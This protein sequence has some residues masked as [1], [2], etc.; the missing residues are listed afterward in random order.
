L[1]GIS[2]MNKILALVFALAMTVSCT[3]PGGL[4]K[5]NAPAV[6]GHEHPSTDEL[7]AALDFL[8]KLVDEVA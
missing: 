5:N 2:K 1:D 7:H 4:L 3:V 8:H 6:S